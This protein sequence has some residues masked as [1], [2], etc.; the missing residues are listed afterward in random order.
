MHRCLLYTS[1]GDSGGTASTGLVMSTT[2]TILGFQ[3]LGD[4]LL[5][6][7]TYQ[8]NGDSFDGL[9]ADIFTKNPEAVIDQMKE[10]VN[11]RGQLS[12]GSKYLGGEG[13]AILRAG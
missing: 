6:Q 12:F 13:F 1:V 11:E 2:S 7:A 4:P 8:L 3:R 9:H 5:A 10:I